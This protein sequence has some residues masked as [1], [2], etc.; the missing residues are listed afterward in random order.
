M[1]PDG[2]INRHLSPGY[3]IE[4]SIVSALSERSAPTLHTLPKTRSAGEAINLIPMM[5]RQLG[6][7]SNH[8]VSSDGHTLLG[9]TSL[10][11]E[12]IDQ[13][14][15]LPLRGSLNDVPISSSF[16]ALPELSSRTCAM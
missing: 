7:N 10:L 1:C 13:G 5:N 3:A 9:I 11:A 4:T 12:I 2:N 16:S 15:S 6:S 8:V 14:L